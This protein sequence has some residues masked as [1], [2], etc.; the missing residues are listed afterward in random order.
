MH[1]RRAW[2]I[3]AVFVGLGLLGL[4]W[5]PPCTLPSHVSQSLADDAAALTTVTPP[6]G[7]DPQVW[8]LLSLAR[9]RDQEHRARQTHCPQ[10]VDL[11]QRIS[12]WLYD[13]HLV[14]VQPSGWFQLAG[15][16]LFIPPALLVYGLPTL[17][18]IDRRKRNKPAIMA[19]NLLLGWTVVGWIGAF[20]WAMTV[21]Q[22]APR[23]HPPTSQPEQEH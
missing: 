3:V 19:C 20:I 12:G 1:Q 6:A 11:A 16:A 8:R 13:R 10:S 22:P 18:A 23:A 2:S 5:H 17:V 4:Y 14:L 7:I 15:I 21:D 9:L